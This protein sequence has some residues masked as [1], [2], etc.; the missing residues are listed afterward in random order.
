MRKRNNNLNSIAAT[1]LG[2]LTTIVT[3][4]A[5]IDI[6]ALDWQKLSTYFKLLVVIMPA[7]GGYLSEIKQTKP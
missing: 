5:V 7:V 4:M 6:D 2:L 1:M 3:A